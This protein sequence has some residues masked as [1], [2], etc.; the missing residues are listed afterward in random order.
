M[1]EFDW[2]GSTYAGTH[3][4]LV[5][6]ECWE[7]VQELLDARAETKT[8]KVKHEFAY[9]GV[10]RCGHCGCMLV[11][12][13]KKQQYVYYHCTGNRGKCAEP[14][15]REEVLEGQFAGVLGQLVIPAPIL[16]WLRSTVLESDHT[17][18]A[19]RAKNIKRLEAEDDRLRRRIDA[20]YADKL[21]W[22]DRSGDLRSAR[23]RM[24]RRATQYSASDSGHPERGTRA[25]GPRDRHAEFDQS[26]LPF[27]RPATCCRTASTAASVV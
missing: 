16:E 17:E 8:R 13:L 24:A 2:D 7:R 21:G 5:S 9:S 19:A 4:P 1:G 26:G 12:E 14:Y 18:Q 20:L 10:V 25:I 22:S 11:G 3:E 15:T 27:I 6:R 23:R